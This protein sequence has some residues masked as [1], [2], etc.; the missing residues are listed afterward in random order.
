VARQYAVNYKTGEAILNY[1]TSTASDGGAPLNARAKNPG[2]GNLGS[3]DRVKT[4]GDGIPSGVV[5]LITAGGQ[6]KM[7]TGIGG[8]IASDNPPKGGSLIPLY[9]RQK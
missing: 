9:W 8:A 4:T 7:L 5:I 1:D 6:T 2:G 3:T